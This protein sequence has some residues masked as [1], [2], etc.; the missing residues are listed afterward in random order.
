MTTY[1]SPKWIEIE[2]S[3]IVQHLAMFGFK[4][5]DI[6]GSDVVLLKEEYGVIITVTGKNHGPAR[7]PTKFTEPVVVAFEGK[8]H[9]TAPAMILFFKSAREFCNSMQRPM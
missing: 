5:E 9:G 4:M 8:D 7:P 2:N 6:G 3:P 1:K